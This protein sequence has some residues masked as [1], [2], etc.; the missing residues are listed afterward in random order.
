MSGTPQETAEGKLELT[1]GGSRFCL[2]KD[3]SFF[4]A[5]TRNPSVVEPLCVLFGSKGFRR[6][7]VRLKTKSE[8]TLP[9]FSGKFLFSAVNKFFNY[10]KPLEDVAVF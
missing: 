5:E 6:S 2:V 10:S 4:T 1:L 8:D 7:L 3:G 9:L